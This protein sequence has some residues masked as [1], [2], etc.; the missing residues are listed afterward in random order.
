[1]SN[2]K[3]FTS[4]PTRMDLTS[5]AVLVRK[6]DRHLTNPVGDETVL[7]DMQTGDYLGL[8]PVA[9]TIWSLLRTPHTLNS[10]VKA[11][12]EEY[13]VGEEDCRRDTLEFLQRIDAMGLID[14]VS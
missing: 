1:M 10:L 14:R 9:S 2:D 5:D 11:L 12:M 13:E 4:K 3:T 8:D 7:L 6:D